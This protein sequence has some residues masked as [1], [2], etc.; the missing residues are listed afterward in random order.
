MV[1]GH[2]NA[3]TNYVSVSGQAMRLPF[4]SRG[5]GAVKASDRSSVI[6]DIDDV[7]TEEDAAAALVSSHPSIF[8]IEAIVGSRVLENGREQLA[9][10]W[11]G[12]WPMSEKVTWQSAAN[13]LANDKMDFVQ[14]MVD[15]DIACGDQTVPKVPA[16]HGSR[17]R[18]QPMPA[19]LLARTRSGRVQKKTR[20]ASSGEAIAQVS[21]VTRN[22]GTVTEVADAGDEAEPTVA[23]SRASQPL[24]AGALAVHTGSDAAEEDYDSEA[25]CAFSEVSVGDDWRATG[26]EIEANYQAALLKRA[27][28]SAG[29]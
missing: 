6:N 12:D 7:D 5:L 2:I 29:L 13:F 21:T 3:A 17:P 24:T 23:D 19:S 9:V 26:R 14:D 1:A 8:A 20:A 27:N 15:L 16:R 25:D 18:R 10:V 11:A 28:E 4:L 22:N